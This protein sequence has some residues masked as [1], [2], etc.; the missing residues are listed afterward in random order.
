MITLELTTEEFI[1]LSRIIKRAEKSSMKKNINPKWIKKDGC[2][3]NTVTGTRI[4]IVTNKPI[5]PD[6]GAQR[7]GY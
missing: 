4:D 1:I 7:I 6:P 5:L 2:M 3:V